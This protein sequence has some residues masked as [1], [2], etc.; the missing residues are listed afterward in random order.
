MT[1]E[2][3]LNLS[4]G[5]CVSSTQSPYAQNLIVAEICEDDRSLNNWRSK[6]YPDAKRLCKLEKDNFHT[7]SVVFENYKLN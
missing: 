4:L 3:W 2:E 1:E 5:D 7:W 6:G